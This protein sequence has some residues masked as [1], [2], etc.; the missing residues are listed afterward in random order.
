[1]DGFALNDGHLGAV[2]TPRHEFAAELGVDLI[3][4]VKHFRQNGLKQA[5]V[6]LF[7]RFRHDGMVRVGKRLARNFERAVE[8]NAFLHKQADEFRYAHGRVRVVELNGHVLGKR[9]DGSAL[10]LEAIDDILQRRTGEEILCSLSGA[11][12]PLPWSRWDKARG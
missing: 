4:D 10:A 8:R 9:V 2:H 5:D 11:F 6:P 7:E 1:M 12:C 3:D